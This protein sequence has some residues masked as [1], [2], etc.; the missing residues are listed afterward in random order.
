VGIYE[1]ISAA[2][3]SSAVER[4]R[5]VQLRVCCAR[6]V[7][8]VLRALATAEAIAVVI[9]VAA[10]CFL[11][12]LAQREP[13]CGFRCGHRCGHRWS[14]R[15]MYSTIA[16]GSRTPPSTL[17]FEWSGALELGWT[18]VSPVSC[19]NLLSRV[20][21]WRARILQPTAGRDG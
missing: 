1:A 9:A 3:L 4:R 14:H 19:A 2:G 10:H 12:S 21:V 6:V 15:R 16:G 11:R 8:H 13:R 20:R 17:L 5:R 18:G 7:D